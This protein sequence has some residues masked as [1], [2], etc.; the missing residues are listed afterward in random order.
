[1]VLSATPT[2]RLPSQ[3]PAPPKYIR[4]FFFGAGV[5]MVVALGSNQSR[6]VC[7][8]QRLERR[9]AACGGRGFRCGSVRIRRRTVAATFKASAMTALRAS[10]VGLNGP[11]GRKHRVA[12]PAK[13]SVALAQGPHEPVAVTVA[14]IARQG[15]EWPLKGTW[16]L[17]GQKNRKAGESGS[18]SGHPAAAMGRTN[19]VR[20]TTYSQTSTAWRT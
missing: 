17:A 18:R 20:E 6:F 16:V 9:S 12:L 11:L 3:G 14:G 19:R 2:V 1:V 4:G 7:L 13:P 10:A 8:A 5:L 15:C